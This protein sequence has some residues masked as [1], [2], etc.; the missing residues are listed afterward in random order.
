[1]S[2]R[3]R[4]I[5]YPLIFFALGAA[6]RDKLLQRVEAKEIVCESVSIVDLHNPTQVLAELSFRRAGPNDPTQLA[7]KVGQ[8]LLVDSDGNDIGEINTHAFLPRV[9]TV[10][11]QVVNPDGQPVVSAGFEPAPVPGTLVEGQAPAVAYHGVI[12][13]NNRPLGAV[14]QPAQPAEDTPPTP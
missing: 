3:E 5:V 6:M 13:L 8:L 14:T 9:T 4:W 11:F 7:E 2:D 1:M 12:Y 10:E